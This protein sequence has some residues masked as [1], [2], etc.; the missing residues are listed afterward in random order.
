MGI[1]F[2]CWVISQYYFIYFIAE[3]IP[4]LAIGGFFSWLQ[5]HLVILLSRCIFYHFSSFSFSLTTRWSSLILYISW[6]TRGNGY[7]PRISGSFDW[8][9]ILYC[10]F[11]FFFKQHNEVVENYCDTICSEMISDKLCHTLSHWKRTVFSPGRDSYYL[12]AT[13]T[14]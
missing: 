12:T 13:Q 14:A 5:C 4:N 8:R 6:T 11:F 9:V 7:S 3:I 2:I 1:H 10:V